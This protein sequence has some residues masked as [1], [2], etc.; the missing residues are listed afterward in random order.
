MLKKY[1]LLIIFPIVII[2]SIIFISITIWQKNNSQ[3][4]ILLELKGSHAVSDTAE[5]DVSIDTKNFTINAAEAYLNFDPKYL[6][7]L[8]VNTTGSVFKI[9]IEGEPKFSNSDGT[10]SFAGGLPTPGF[11]GVDKMGTIKVKFIKKGKTEI[12]FT[13]KSRMLL[14]DGEGT[15]IPLKMEPIQIK[16]SS[17]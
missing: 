12:S 6:E 3:S 8:S 7:V 2:F 1:K 11:K 14:N 15:E 9:W 10:I 13:D 17:K 5:I 16:I 4:K